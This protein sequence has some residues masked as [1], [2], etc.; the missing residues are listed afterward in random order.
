MP[1]GRERVKRRDG[2]GFE[3]LEPRPPISFQMSVETWGLPPWSSVSRV[4]STLPDSAPGVT[5]WLVV[6]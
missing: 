2:L 6:T 1:V 4:I 5:V 3:S